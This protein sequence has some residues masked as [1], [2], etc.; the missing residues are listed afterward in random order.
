M[1][2]ALRTRNPHGLPVNGRPRFLPPDKRSGVPITR[3]EQTYLASMRVQWLQNLIDPRRD[4]DTECGYPSYLSAAVYRKMYDREG[5]AA[6][7]VSI[8]PDECWAVDPEVYET[9]QAATTATEDVWNELLLDEEKNPYHYLHRLDVQSGIGH[10]GVMLLGV[11]TPSGYQSLETPLPG[12]NDRGPVGSPPAG[13]QLL[14]LRVFDESQA[15]IAGFDEDPNSPRYGRPT[16]YELVF[17][18]TPGQESV[19]LAGYYSG[20]QRRRVHWSRIIHAADNRETNEVF[21]TPRMRNVFNRLCDLRKV[22]GGSAEMFWKGGFPGYS[23]ELHPDLV[24]ADVELDQVSIRGELDAY[25]N[26]L[27]RYLAIKGLH[28]VSL[29]PQVASPEHTIMAQ[30]QAIAMSIGV[31][32]R[33]FL[34][35]EQA[36]LASGQDVK[37]WNRRLVRRQSRYLT[38]MLVRPLLNR[39]IALGVLPEPRQTLRVRWPDID[40]PNEEDKSKVADRRTASLL[41][42]MESAGWQ[43]I[44]PRLF[45]AM[46]MGFSDDEA[47]TIMQAL[48]QG[49]DAWV[50]LVA[51]QVMVAKEKAKAPPGAP[52]GGGAAA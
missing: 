8:Y 28:A 31:P 16:V 5:P 37:T 15:V 13:T 36:Q 21:G 49:D 10:Y 45:L 18:D 22:L 34:G 4:L 32:L 3:N 27:Q 23:F 42:Y 38:P 41:K 1:A 9:E 2:V 26:G 52:F 40:L 17:G 43:L 47:D 14:Y 25:S 35:A 30:F 12:F 6:R 24:N 44:P 19:H 20:T 7:V 51:P 29:A 48:K 11:S 50:K 39:L 33:I 46:V